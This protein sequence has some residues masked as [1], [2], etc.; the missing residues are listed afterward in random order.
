MQVLIVDDSKLIRML[1]AECITDLGHEI[2]H[3]ENGVDAVE[4]IKSHSPDL[5]MM[6]VEMPGLN[7]FE[8]TRQIRVIKGD[9]WFPI[10]F[11]SAKVDEA[12]YEEGIL[13]GGDA[14]LE[15]PI[16]PWRLQLQI[17]A[18][19][20]I[21]VM[22]Q[23]LKTAQEELMLINE[24]YRKL[25]LFDELTGL[26]NRRN[27]DQ[28]LG[29]EFKLAKRDKNPLSVVLCDIDFFKI[30]NDTYGHQAGDDCL[31]K[32]AEALG[33]SSNRPT[34]LACR[35]GGEEFT[36]ILPNTDLSGA[37]KFSEKVRLAVSDLEIMHEGSK[38]LPFVSL[39]LG[40]AT[41]NGQFSSGEGITK[42]A[43]AALYKAKENGR[44]RVEVS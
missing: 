10:I 9:D 4:Y 5:I 42:Q 32:V 23:K 1:V 24:K 44:N 7:G 8:T 30:Y 35:Y 34:D 25:S 11:L 27:F 22:R 37:Q 17:K 14:Y 6:D 33:K 31:A 16:E 19:E 3:M 26:A 38:V 28:T 40:V 36:F 20:R 13:A 2:I 12:S 18:M 21:Y 15:K 29:R 43:D 41:Y 39:S